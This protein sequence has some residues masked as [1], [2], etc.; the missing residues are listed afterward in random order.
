[1]VI[2][3]N[4]IKVV[5]DLHAKVNDIWPTISIGID[6]HRFDILSLV[7]S[8]QSVIIDHVLEPGTHKLWIDIGDT[9][10]F[11]KDPTMAIIV[12]SIR[13]QNLQDEL[14]IFSYYQPHYPDHWIEEN[15]RD[16]RE[17]PAIIHSNYLGWPGRW[18]LDFD[19]P[20]YRW[21]HQRLN[22]GWLI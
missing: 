13:F 11:S 6:D 22:L 1:M 12:K 10:A 16:G 19:T 3:Y 5:L 14:A 8:N 20:I 2:Q 17:L 9:V 15:R 21:L 7:K 18:W 4:N